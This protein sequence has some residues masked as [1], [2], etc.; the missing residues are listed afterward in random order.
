MGFM[1]YQK[2]FAT[3]KIPIK[4]ITANTTTYN[5]TGRWA[6]NS[7]VTAGSSDIYDFADMAPIPQINDTQWRADSFQQAKDDFI[8]TWTT[9]IVM[10]SSTVF[11]AFL[12]K[13]QFNMF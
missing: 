7:N 4:N 5:D 2:Y 12:Q 11:L 9:I 10:L 8:Q 3:I 13:L 1:G 6:I